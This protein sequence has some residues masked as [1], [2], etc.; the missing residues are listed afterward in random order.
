M[1]KIFIDTEKF[2][3]LY[4][5]SK[6]ISKI[7]QDFK[8][9]QPFLVFTRQQIDEFIRNR[10]N[11]IDG[12]V[13]QIKNNRLDETLG[14][15]GIIRQ[16]QKF[17]K[18]RELQDKIKELKKELIK[19]F[20]RIRDNPNEDKIFQ[21]FNE[22]I[23]APNVII[24][25]R[26]DDIIEKAQKRKLIGN[27]PT[28]KDKASVGDE[29]NWESLLSKIN[30]DLIII[31]GDST[32]IKHQTF[33]IRE[34]ER[35]KR[36]KKI[37]GIFNEISEALPLIHETPSEELKNFEEEQ[38]NLPEKVMRNFLSNTMIDFTPASG[39]TTDTSGNIVFLPSTMFNYNFKKPFFNFQIN[40][41]FEK[42]QEDEK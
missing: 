29:I 37:L 39:S 21:F 34:F 32:Y 38:K 6:D 22:L 24:I 3:E 14:K 10:D 20:L 33:L 41:E 27:P 16:F 30:D 5:T 31:S 2:I 36:N 9:L 11:Q 18:I 19:E 35:E 42:K 23:T 4:W 25:E 40:D 8:K 15:F 7:F 12:I 13:L 28:T 17:T 26:T 1:P